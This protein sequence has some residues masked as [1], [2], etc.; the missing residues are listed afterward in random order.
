MGIPVV[1]MGDIIRQ[2]VIE[3]DLPL[4]DLNM[5]EVSRRMRE[6]EGMDAIARRCIPVIEATGAPVVLV[7]GIRGDAEVMAFRR[8][9][10]DFILVGIDSPFETRLRR[11]S[12]RGRPDDLLDGEELLLRDRREVSFGL[13]NALAMADFQV[14]ND[15]TLEAF[16]ATVRDLVNRLRG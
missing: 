1:I 4:S 6:R 2:A 15:G 12:E 9:F 5:G 11:L 16:T 10:A 8:H 7:D 13:G 14:R 3:A